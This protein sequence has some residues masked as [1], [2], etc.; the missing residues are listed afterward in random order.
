MATGPRFRSLSPEEEERRLGLL[1]IILIG[2]AV[3]AALIGLAVI[4][5]WY[6]NPSPLTFITI[7]PPWL[8]LPICA[9]AYWLARRKRLYLA[10]YVYII[11]TVFLVAS[12]I[13][14]VGGAQGPMA[15]FFIW[16]I[17]VAGMLI[18]VRA[19]FE[20]AALV[21]AIYL[22]FALGELGGW[23]VPPMDVYQRV[24]EYIFPGFAMLL[25]W[26]VALL[27]RLFSG[28]LQSALDKARQLTAELQAHREELEEQVAL[29]TADLERRAVQI[30]VA[31][32]V[33]RD[34]TAVLDVEALMRTTVERIGER[35]GFYH[36][37]IF[38]L[39]EGGEYAV[40]RAAS[41]EGGKRMLAR[42]HKLK[43]GEEGIVGYVAET[44]RPRIALDVGEDA[45]WFDNPD[46]PHTR[47]EMALPLK[48]R[49][50]VIGV[51][52]V[53]STQEAAFKEEDIPVLQLLADQLATALENAR[54]FA[55]AR[56]SLEE[57]SRL[58]QAMTGEAWR[59]FTTSWP[60]LRRFQR[61]ADAVPEEA[62]RDLFA[63]ARSQGQPVRGFWE[64][65]EGGWYLLAVPVRLRNVPIGVVG[66][67]RPQEAGEWRR[68]EIVFAE[69][70]AERVAL[71]LENV[72]LFEEAQ[73]RA[74]REQW[75][76]QVTARMQRSLDLETVMR[77]AVREIG[78]AI[79]A[80]KVQLR[81]RTDGLEQEG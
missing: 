5:V 51:L 70:L 29:R 27:T 13:Y 8:A 16:F 58:Y 9:F 4:A 32:E 23:I 2:Q 62:W 81:L 56:S 65:G 73:R 57:L 42:G 44:G 46:L 60:D 19:A 3:G 12:G 10:T 24:A 39:D 18:D 7:F 6:F 67:H 40:L 75:I 28:S 76:S 15:Y 37:G 79:G 80:A 77:A 47:S 41:S 17:L 33:A 11:A 31:A 34:A 71:S 49:G 72:R 25:F 26:L 66:F 78:Q 74:Q 54:L 61:G 14:L 43:V 21:T 68:E 36:V 69:S 52:D 38:L 59:R 63:Q 50:R 55:Q 20:V 53:Q 35:F 1:Q 64:N 48:V 45:A 30:Q 22:F